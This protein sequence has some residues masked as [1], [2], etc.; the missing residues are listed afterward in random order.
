MKQ[1]GITIW[2]VAVF[3]STASVA[4]DLVQVFTMSL[5]SDPQLLAEAASRQA[6]GELDA[7]AL[8]QFLPQVDLNANDGYIRQDTS[9]QSFLSGDRDFN[10]HGYTLSITQPIYHRQ[11]FVQKAQA[12][13]SIEGAQA[14]YLVAEQALIIRVS[15]RYFEV[16]ARQDA[17]SF[18]TAEHE[19]I[20]QQLEQTTQRFDVGLS[21]ITDVTESQAAYDLSIASIILA[22][23][24]LANSKERLR[25]IAGRYLDTLSVLKAET[26]LVSPDP[27][28]IDQWTTLALEQ[29]PIMAVAKAAVDNAGQSI[30]F[31]RSGHY[32]SLDV[33][34][35]KSYSSQSDSSFGGG[36]KTHQDSVS[37]QFNLP[38]YTG[39]AVVSRTREAGYRLDQAMQN[40]EQ[41]RREVTRQTREAYNQVIAGISQ[42][43]ALKQAVISS[44]KALESTEAGFEVGT[45]TTVDVLSVRRELFRALRDHARSRYDYILSTLR[46]KQAAGIVSIDDLNQINQ[47]LGS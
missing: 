32:P 35:Q 28:D 18:A 14:S 13:I 41:Q 16:L 9:S 43:K 44:E 11:N 21:T 47:W 10:D 5:K 36:H 17:L 4:E 34:G 39:G 42:V 7:Q 26:P 37:L 2:L 15:E 45:R 25:E 33:V 23:T 6:V 30:E 40:Q 8:A 24:I 38:I 19:A 20:S 3:F 46:L 1:L 22:E 27:E 12:D 29:N 31:Q